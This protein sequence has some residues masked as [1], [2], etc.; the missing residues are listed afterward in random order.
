MKEKRLVLW[1]WCPHPERMKVSRTRPLERPWLPLAASALILSLLA[2]QGMQLWAPP[3]VNAAYPTNYAT[4]LPIEPAVQALTETKA[5]S[6]IMSV[7][8]TEHL[9]VQLAFPDTADPGQSISVTASTRAK[10]DTKVIGLSIE[11]FSY[12]DKQLI[13][14]AGET[15][16]KDIEVHSGDTWQTTLNLVVPGI[17]QRSAMIG[18]VT[19]V[20]EETKSYSYGPYYYQYYP[21]YYPYQYDPA[22]YPYRYP[23]PRNYTYYYVYYEPLVVTTQKSSQQTVPLTYVLATTPEYEALAAKHEQLRQEYDALVAKHNDLSSKYESLK[24]EYEQ[25]V[26]KYNQLQSSYNSAV[27][28]LAN[29]KI[30]TYVLIV[31]V[32]ALALALIASMF[33]RRQVVQPAE[34]QAEVT[35]SPKKHAK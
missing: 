14:A 32:L 30:V 12:I 8:S 27:S 6:Q 4:F 5:P 33:R 7:V 24:S 3:A 31:A 25:T 19:E 26:A 18:T 28:E 34:K 23:Y 1:R 35:Q 9:T 29:Y 13:K 21:S 10:S 20:W 11:I 2:V 15:V 17:A 16:L 22:Y